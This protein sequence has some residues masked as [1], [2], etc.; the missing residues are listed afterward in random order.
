[1]KT[2]FR[3]ILSSLAV[4]L[5]AR[6]QTTSIAATPAAGYSR[7]TARGASDSF[8]SIPFVQR[9]ALIAHVSAVDHASVTLSAT[10]LADGIYA[11][12]SSA[13]YYLQF[14]SG[15]LSGLCY[16]ILNNQG[17]GFTLDTRGDDLTAHPLGT[18]GTGS[19]GDLVRIR[20]FWT[21]GAVFGTDSAQVPL[22]PVSSLNGSV[23]SGADAILVPDNVSPGTQKQPAKVLGFVTGS[24]WRERSDTSIDASATEL[25][26]GMPFIIRRQ[27]STPVDIP[28]IGYVSADRFVQGIP[29]LS[30]GADMDLAVSLAYPV[31]AALADSGLSSTDS[32]VIAASAD[33]LHL[34]DV[35]LGYPV[36]RPGFSLPPDRRFYVTGT[37]W[38]ES[39]T[40]ADQSTLQPEAG[41]ILRFR[42]LHSAR[43][44]V[45]LP[46]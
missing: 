42:G 39:E 46:P 29:A 27:N 13:V 35:V 37:H 7:L 8:V 44:W 11:P 23:Y 12:G 9:S 3:I 20:P 36:S 15:N 32:P 33:S 22:D 16:R 31:P 28:V 14:V 43:Y 38:F 6:A 34:G 18:V 40:T 45:Q 25:W 4:A 41:Y 30:A 5:A 17:N 2:S 10:G 19:S 1:M 21:V 24:G 26:P